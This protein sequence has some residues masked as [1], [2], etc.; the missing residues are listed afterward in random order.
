MLWME[1]RASSQDEEESLDVELEAL[2]C[3]VLPSK[4]DQLRKVKIWKELQDISQLVLGKDAE[5]WPFGSSANGCGERD[6]DMDMVV[7]HPARPDRNKRDKV[8]ALCALG[9]VCDVQGFVVHELRSSSKV[10]I[11]I[12]EKD[13]F[14]IDVSYNNLLPLLNTRLLRSYTLLNPRLSVV[15]LAVK[16]W[17]KA[18]HIAKSYEGFISSYAWTL[19]VVYYFQI[20]RQLPC[21]H[22]LVG[23]ETPIDFAAR[24]ATLEEA[25]EAWMNSPPP[26]SCAQLLRGFFD[27]YANEFDWKQDVVSVRLGQRNSTIRSRRLIQLK[28]KRMHLHIEDPID[29]RRNLNFALT[30]QTADTIHLEI[31]WVEQQL[32]N[33]FG[34]GA[35]GIKIPPW[36]PHDWK[37]CIED[38]FLELPDRDQLESVLPEGDLRR[39]MKIKGSGLYCCPD[40]MTCFRSLHHLEDHRAAK[41]HLGYANRLE[42][43]GLLRSMSIQE[44]RDVWRRRLEHSPEEKVLPAK[45][46]MYCCQLCGK[47]F[48]RLGDLDQHVESTGH[49]FLLEPDVLSEEMEEQGAQLKRSEPE[50]PGARRRKYLRRPT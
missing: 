26:W 20:S 11:L 23:E 28:N 7:S 43:K 17:A 37:Q 15:A 33:G 9:E 16:R 31:G 41:E 35:L 47:S 42:L 38:G 32:K 29:I 12:L 19:M 8:S 22:A 48:L 36:E 34:L 21:L 50:R 49:L 39:V 40:C 3:Q 24:F 6:A 2:A 44:M 25:H 45:K 27:F 10:P 13:G 46:G 5:V 1:Q 30:K 18:H 4:E 14:D